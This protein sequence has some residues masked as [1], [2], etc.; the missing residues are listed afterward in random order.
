MEEGCFHFI[1]GNLCPVLELEESLKDHLVNLFSDA[2]VLTVSLPGGESALS[3]FYSVS[4]SA[5]ISYK[6][7]LIES[8]SYMNKA[9]VSFP[10]SS[11]YISLN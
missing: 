2:L 1:T 10:C 3:S 7:M 4:N 5:T 9:D 6:L 11:F 8:S